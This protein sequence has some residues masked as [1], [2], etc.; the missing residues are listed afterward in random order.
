MADDYEVLAQVSAFGFTLIMMLYYLNQSVKRQGYIPHKW[1]LAATFVE[2][3]VLVGTFYFLPTAFK[4]LVA[5]L[6]LSTAVVMFHAAIKDKSGE[7][8]S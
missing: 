5:I 6:G 1:V 2:S 7:G 4:V 3:S 8:K